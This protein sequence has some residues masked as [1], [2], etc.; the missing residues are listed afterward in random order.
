MG[1]IVGFLTVK[2]KWRKKCAITGQKED[3]DTLKISA[4]PEN[5]AEK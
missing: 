2:D 5:T 3:V 4:D 1:K